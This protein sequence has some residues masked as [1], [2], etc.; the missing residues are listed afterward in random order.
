[1][2]DMIQSAKVQLTNPLD[3]AAESLSIN[4]EGTNIT[5]E[6]AD[7]M[8]ILTGE[9]TA[10]NYATALKTLTYKNTNLDADPTSRTVEISV[11]DGEYD[12][13]V[14]TST[15][16]INHAPDLLPI[17]DE[18]VEA[19][20]SNSITIEATDRNEGDELFLLLDVE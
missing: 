3:G 19:G 18:T 20:Q 17:A 9:D 10:E 6:Y 4:V 5:V 8:L 7:C 2:G 15:I 13:E 1:N 12:S 11:N 16:A 14:A